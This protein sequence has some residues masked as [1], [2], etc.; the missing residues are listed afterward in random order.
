MS[1]EFPIFDISDQN[2]D[3]FEQMGTK[4]KFWYTDASTGEEF[5]FKSIHTQDR[6]GNPIERNGENWAEKIACELAESLGIPHAQYD[7]A[8]YQKE[9]GIRSKKFTIP[10]D[11]MFFAN[12]L[13]EHVAR[14]INTPIERDQR[15]QTVDRVTII[16]ERLIEYPPL[17]WDATENIKTALDVFIGY[18]MLDTLISNQDRHN[19][20][21]AMIINAGKRH[22]APSFDHAAS[23]G[24]N[25]SIAEM[26]ERL[27]S[28]DKGRQISTYVGKSKSHFYS[29][30]KR[31]KTLD[32]F[33]MFG[34]QSK[35]AAL[36]WL[37]RLEA[38][39]F[40]EMQEIIIRVPDLI[41]GVT[42]KAFCFALLR[43]NKV[44]ILQC[45]ELFT[46]KKESKET[47]L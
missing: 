28:N 42:E 7:L 29:G 25:E 17:K 45:K 16:L 44:R 14:G 36:E 10:G 5:L 37:K 35:K 20:N 46:D 41:M 2:I 8:N 21:W 39:K 6:H 22:L 38:F 47:M 27:S 26:K 1:I 31:L 11:N 3:D 32:A 40:Q 4:S 13:I 12:Q 19:E 18:L 43:A 24:R 34:L 30:N 9:K 33:V 23:L 15:S